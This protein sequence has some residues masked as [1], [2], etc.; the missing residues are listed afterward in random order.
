MLRNLHQ[1]MKVKLGLAGAFALGLVVI[2]VSIIRVVTIL[3]T[4][5]IF[6]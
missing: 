6:L 2:V 1:P 4:T 3:N 5:D